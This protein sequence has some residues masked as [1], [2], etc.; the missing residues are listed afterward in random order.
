M[1]TGETIRVY[2]GDTLPVAY[3]CRQPDPDDPTNSE[4]IPAIPIS[5]KARLLSRST[6]TFVE[7][8]G[9]GVTEVDADIEG[10]IVRYTVP[11]AFTLIPSDYLLYVTVTFADGNKLTEDQKFKVQEFR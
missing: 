8:G 3:E 6:G 2:T 10:N 4:G 11:S 1:A 9:T 5:A 7:L